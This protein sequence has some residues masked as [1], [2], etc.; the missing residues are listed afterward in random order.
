MK[1]RVIHQLTERNFDKE[2][3]KSELEVLDYLEKNFTNIPFL[4]VIKVA[5]ESFT[6]Q[7]TVNRAC[8]LLG[9]QGFSEMKYAAKED[10]E[11]MNSTSERHIANTEY[12][13]RKINFD[14]AASVSDA[15][16]DSRRKLMIFGLGGSNI[17]A[18]YLQRQLLYLGIPSLLVAEM[19]MFKNFEGYSLIVL[20]SSGETQRC[21]QIA[22]EAKK[23]KMK[24]ISITKNESSLMKLS[25]CCF[26]HDV[27]V[28]KMKG[29]SREQQLH[30]MI[31]VNEVVD[32]LKKKLNI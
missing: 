24:V 12:I 15:I 17:S 1:Y 30:I 20:S 4:S 18:L 2:A 7:A 31:M 23:L 29:I 11:L 6:S 3:S 14:G 8:K 9:F 10:I 22:K 19:Q 25:D 13:L 16:I 27:P 28:D 32:Q 26:Y 5:N 21:L